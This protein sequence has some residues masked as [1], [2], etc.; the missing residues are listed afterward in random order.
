MVSGCLFG[1]L[2]SEYRAAV[3]NS[4][5]H[6]TRE[7][8]GRKRR[9]IG[10]MCQASHGWLAIPRETRE[11]IDHRWWF[12]L[13][14]SREF[15]EAAKR[16]IYKTYRP[17][18]SASRNARSIDEW[19]RSR[20]D[21]IIRERLWSG[22][23]VLFSVRTVGADRHTSWHTYLPQTFLVGIS[24]LAISGARDLKKKTR[25]DISYQTA[26]NVI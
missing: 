15:V 20:D 14:T 11:T 22:P 13:V 7:R 23:M 24:K 2:P 18:T 17:S 25:K 1:H 10:Q 9:M 16:A 19:R 8:K 3:I 12:V 4:I 26:R 21:D 6:A 5:I